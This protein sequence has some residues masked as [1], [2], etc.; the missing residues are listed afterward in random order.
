MNEDD[1][2]ENFYSKIED[3]VNNDEFMNTFKELIQSEEINRDNLKELID[4]VFD[5][6]ER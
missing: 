3:Y 1:F 2:L 4:G 6:K 5:G